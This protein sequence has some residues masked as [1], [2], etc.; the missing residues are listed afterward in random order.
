MTGRFD[1]LLDL[2]R[3]LSAM[4][5]DEIRMIESRNPH[6][7]AEHEEERS[8]LALL[9]QRELQAMRESP[10]EIRAL[11]REKIEQ[12]K[13]E[14]ATFNGALDRHRRMISRMRRVTEGIIKAVADEATQQRA[15]KVTY[16]RGGIA[17]SY[18]RSAAA[19][20]AINRKV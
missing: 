14:T 17:A 9:Y 12:L 18:G 20:L 1:V 19:P 4:V 16:G 3:R 6:R 2:T 8:R 5:E 7:L 11:T 13:D 10:A 15:P